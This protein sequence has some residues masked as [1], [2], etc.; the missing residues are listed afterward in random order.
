MHS[1]CSF[2]SLN[3][4]NC[5]L[6]FMPWW[7]PY[8]AVIVGA[9]ILLV[10]LL[11][12]YAR[13]GWLGVVATFSIVSLV[14]GFLAGR[15]SVTQGYTPTDTPQVDTPVIQELDKPKVMFPD[16]KLPWEK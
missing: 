1:A 10:I 7:L 3:L 13:T 4:V 14:V 15:K 12:I 8:I 2:F 9:F 16:L 6:S 5:A 11:E